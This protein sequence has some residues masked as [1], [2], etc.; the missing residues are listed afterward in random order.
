MSQQDLVS[1]LVEIAESEEVVMNRISKGDFKGAAKWM[2]YKTGILLI[3]CHM[4]I[5]AIAGCSLYIGEG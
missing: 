2:N 3:G 1:F 4:A 5:N